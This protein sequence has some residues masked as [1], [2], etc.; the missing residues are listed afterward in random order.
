MKGEITMEDIMI[1]QEKEASKTVVKKE[2]IYLIVCSVLLGVLFDF[3]FYKKALG[4]SYTLFVIAFYLVFLGILRDKIAFR[5]SFGWFLSIPIIALSATYFVFSNQIF[6]TLNFLII[7]ILIIAQTILITQENNHKW[8][9]ASFIKDIFYGIFN[10]AFSHTSK[11]FVIILSSLRIR[12]S[13]KKYDVFMKILIG[14]TIS[15]PLLIIIV[16]LLASADRIF[17]HLMDEILSSFGT[18]NIGDFSLQGIIALLIMIIVF[19]YIWSFSNPSQSIQAQMQYSLE[20]NNRSWDP[21]ISITILVAINSVYLVFT[22]IQFAYMFGALNNALPPDFTYAEYA[23]R[24]FFELLMVTLINFSLVLSSIRFTRKDGKLVSRTVQILHSLLILCTVVILSSAYLRMS[25]YE[26]VYGYTYLRVLTHS[27]MIFL[28][29]LF[30]IAFYK[31]WN[32]RISLLKPYIVIGIIAYLI[33]NFAN[34]DELIANNNLD[35][36]IKTGKLDTYYLKNLSYDSLPVLVNLLEAE[37]VPVDIKKN[38][39]EQQKELSKEQPWQSFNV[40]RQKAKQA[41]SQAKL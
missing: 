28:G 17:Q 35:R 36:Y 4:I 11:P 38:L 33:L 24:G 5:F 18:I 31:I 16:S 7:P 25:L 27:F 3:L 34:I 32:E 37:N 14:L 2:D 41:L 23:R 22:L 20:S 13:S 26:E 6:A 30:V 29:V 40:S 19:S 1:V 9:D 8:Y 15:I 10:R 39:L 21:I 12:K